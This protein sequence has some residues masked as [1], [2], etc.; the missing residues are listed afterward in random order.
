MA[1]EIKM[2]EVM[3]EIRNATEEELREVITDWY[4]RTRTDGLRIGAKYMA[5]GVFGAIQKNLNKAKPSLR[6]Y[7][8]CIKDIKKI[9]AV[10]LT[11]QDEPEDTD[12]VAEEIADEGTA[13]AVD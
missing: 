8:R 13:E 11:Q 7:E 5:A 12:D 1:E 10:Q 2:S 9:I 6:D 3:D 4:E